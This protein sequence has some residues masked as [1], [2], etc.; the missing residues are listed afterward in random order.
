MFLSYL[1]KSLMNIDIDQY[2]IDSQVMC[3]YEEKMIK[4]T[5]SYGQDLYPLYP[6]QFNFVYLLILVRPRS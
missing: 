5:D 2:W 6:Y 3:K 4:E 1:M